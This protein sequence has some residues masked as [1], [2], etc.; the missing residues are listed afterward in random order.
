MCL[1]LTV[2]CPIIGAA[3]DNTVTASVV[4][5][6]EIRGPVYNGSDLPEIL[7]NTAYGDGTTVTMNAD[8][9]ATFYFDDDD[10]VTTEPLFKW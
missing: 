7:S 10:N 5:A 9:L 2:V 4:S 8:K 1:F 6:V 3:A